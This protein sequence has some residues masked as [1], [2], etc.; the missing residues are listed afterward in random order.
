[1]LTGAGNGGSVDAAEGIDLSPVV[2][3]H[4][5]SFKIADAEIVP[6]T[7]E[8]VRAGERHVIEPRVMQL[9]V[10]LHRVAGAVVSKDDLGHLI[11]E[12]RIV[13]EDAINRVVSRLRAVAAKQAG[14]VFTV[15]TITKVG[16][17]LHVRGAATVDDKIVSGSSSGVTS[18][19][20]VLAL[21]GAAA[22]VAAAGGALWLR[23]DGD[24]LPPEVEQLVET[25]E[26]GIIS[27]APDTNSDAIG[28][29]RQ[30]V[31][32]APNSAKVWGLLGAAYMG[33][34]R[35]A[36]RAQSRDF[37]TR[38][39]AAIDRA[40]AIEPGQPDALA[41]QILGM[42]I[43]GNWLLAERAARAG[44]R[45]HPGH[46]GLT[47]KLM[48]VMA[49]AGRTRD[50]L[51][52][53]KQVERGFPDIPHLRTPEIVALWSLGRLDEADAASDR[54]LS[55]WPRFYGIWFT[56]LYIKM[57][58]GHPTEALGM[59]R[60]VGTRPI[61]IPNWN[62]EYVEQQAAALASGDQAQIADAVRAGIEIARKGT[63]FA[64]NAANFASFVGDLDAAFNILKALYFN[65]GFSMPDAYFSSEQGMYAGTDRH[66]YNLF[67][68]P[69]RALRRDPRFADLTRR[70][71]L[72]AYWKASGSRASVTV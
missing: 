38:A 48:Y 11:W 18:R 9:L 24:G 22:A 13:G 21:G 51:A 58:G 23:R 8:I 7:R 67:S 39:Q 37:R 59:V 10:A 63:G 12:G 70:V 46:L 28:A 5:P 69:N 45:A 68:W 1:M 20:Q 71:G 33:A 4:E 72:D 3:A 29:L 61:G 6:A 49:Q 31:E 43:F 64:E 14:G 34:S 52:L 56:T 44:L 25:G 41:G 19:R 15:E 27:A 62:F 30:A 60:D 54:Y 55:R 65:E 2:L 66:T 53:A 26:R 42:R 47:Q 50:A 32:L 57:Y 40:Y 16:Y 36:P 35:D 17:R